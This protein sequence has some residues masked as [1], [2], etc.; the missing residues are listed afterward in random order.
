MKLTCKLC[1]SREDAS[2]EALVVLLLWRSTAFIWR[3]WALQFQAI[4]AHWF[5][6]HR[7]DDL[8]AHHLALRVAGVYPDYAVLR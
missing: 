3:P 8:I 4:L 1:D 6:G 5:C 2:E 7:L